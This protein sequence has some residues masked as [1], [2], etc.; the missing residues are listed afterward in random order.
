M[1]CK[2]RIL[3]INDDGIEAE[4][5]KHLWQALNPFADVTIVAPWTERSGAGV[6]ITLQT[7]LEIEPVA[8]EKNTPAWRVSGTPA[9]C[10]KMSLA[11]ILPSPPDLIVSGINRGSNSGKN[12][13]YSGTIGG[14]IEGVLRNIPGIAFS[15]EDF[16]TPNFHIAEKYI[17]PIVEHILE[18]PLPKGTLLNVNFPTHLGDIKGFKMAR[19]GKGYW[20][21]DLEEKS[22]TD[23]KTHYWLGGMWLHQNEHE[24][25]DVHYL[26]QGYMTAVPIHV[27]ELTDH[28]VIEKRKTSF[29][30][31]FKIN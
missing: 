26:K 4:G 11:K 29:E 18:H 31:L 6:G 23:G 2:P 12:V 9:D 7:H 20:L 19:Q 13:F 25:S 28:D 30:N 1:V 22:H 3:L 15:C 8:W 24:E 21:E 17:Q 10:V 14:V 27:E 5:L 16:E